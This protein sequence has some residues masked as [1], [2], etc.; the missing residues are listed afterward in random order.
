MG[1]PRKKMKCLAELVQELGSMAAAA[2]YLDVNYGTIDRWQKG[3]TTP[4]LSMIRLAR[5]KGIDLT[6]GILSAQLVPL[7]MVKPVDKDTNVL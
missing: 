6:Y 4:S 3:R 2:R 1:A 7:D 5:S